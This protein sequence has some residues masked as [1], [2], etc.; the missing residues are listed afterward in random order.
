M[1][2]AIAA[3]VAGHGA[4]GVVVALVFFGT[5]A[6]IPVAIGL[7]IYLLVQRSKRKGEVGASSSGYGPMVYQGPAPML[8][9]C[10]YCRF[11]GHPDVENKVTSAGWIICFLMLFSCAGTLFCW[12]PLLITERHMTCP[13]CSTRIGG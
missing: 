10:P 11:Q 1:L 2:L 4:L 3:P 13:N 5:L 12:L 6:L 8:W 7:G 9:T